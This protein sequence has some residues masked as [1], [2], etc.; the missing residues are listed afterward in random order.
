MRKAT[1]LTLTGV[2]L[3]QLLTPSQVLASTLPEN[4]ELVRTTTL[5]NEASKHLAYLLR[6]N[7]LPSKRPEFCPLNN[8]ASYKKTV[9]SLKS[10]MTV[11]KDSCFDGNQSL[12]DKLL[13]DS[14]TLETELNK[15]SEEQGK[16]P[17]TDVTV[18]PNA[19]QISG[20]NISQVMTGID[21]LFN[22]NKCSSLDKTPFLVRTADVIQTFSQFGMY[23]PAGI[24]YAYAGLASASILRFINNLFTKRF[25]FE[26]DEDI[27]TFTKLNCAYYDVR[28]QIKEQQVFELDTSRH[29]KDKEIVVE[30]LRELNYSI[31]N[32]N[33]AKKEI[34]IRIKEDREK[35][36][37]N[38]EKDLSSHIEP[39][40][41]K[42]KEPI[43]N[44]T[45]KSARYQ[46]AEIIGELSYKLDSLLVLVDDY[47]NESQGAEKFLNIL[48]KQQLEKLK[49]PESL[50]SLSIKDFNETFL[51][52]ISS[53]FN[54]ILKN[55]EAKKVTGLIDFANSKA[56][57]KNGTTVTYKDIE[58]LLKSKDLKERE[59]KLAKVLATANEINRRIDAII[60]K[61]EYSSEDSHDEGTREIIKSLDVVKNHIYGKYGKQFLE[62]MR[63]MSTKQNKNFKEHYEKFEKKYLI[64]GQI[65]PKDMM[66]ED[67]LVNAC[68]DA[69][70]NIEIWVYAQ[71]LS[72]LGYDF[73]STNNDVFGDPGRQTDRKRI[74]KHSD[75]IVLARRI[76]TALN[77]QKKI[78]NFIELEKET[79]EIEGREYSISEAKEIVKRIEF[80]GNTYTIAEAKELLVDL[81]GPKG[82]RKRKLGYIMLDIV[83]NRDSAIKLQKLYKQYDCATAGTLKK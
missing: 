45:G 68:V 37:S 55:I 73:V 40:Y 16:T 80:Y 1:S 53:S 72:E 49:T 6:T 56:F 42:V 26:N 13:E 28:N 75:S 9:D 46:Q 29:H 50:I 51:V 54:R 20:I 39:L 8:T 44:I 48:F 83:A 57:E 2:V 36:I 30:L 77:Y 33:D 31:D 82:L 25:K 61:K 18:D 27:Q 76:I 71:K 4:V 34:N 64:S 15:L 5:T 62:K 12:I 65:A 69:Q 11:F 47:V 52:D 7:K 24:P 79:I 81:Y 74:K 43:K 59:E 22:K 78:K 14:K 66:S 41:A 35:F 23:T 17:A 58:T 32:I 70:T 3:F 38:I 67:A 63:S 21:T 10:I 19:P 60:G